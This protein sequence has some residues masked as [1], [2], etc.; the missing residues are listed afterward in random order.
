MSLREL[1][2][3][4]TANRPAIGGQRGLCRCRGGRLGLHAEASTVASRW[5]GV[6]EFAAL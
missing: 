2:D 5:L 3:S 6:E 4:V 1:L